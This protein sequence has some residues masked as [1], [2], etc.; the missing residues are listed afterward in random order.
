M[1]FLLQKSAIFISNSRF[2]LKTVN[3]EQFA[4]E[5]K[6]E[7]GVILKGRYC[8]NILHHKRAFGWE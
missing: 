8:C 3:C 7:T 5:Q 1:S 4:K 6:R 2:S